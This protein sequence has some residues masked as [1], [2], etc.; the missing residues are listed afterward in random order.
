MRNAS[1]CW[2]ALFSSFLVCLSSCLLAWFLSKLHRL[3][4]FGGT[5]GANSATTTTKTAASPKKDEGDYKGRAKA[6][7]NNVPT[8]IISCIVAEFRNITQ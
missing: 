8:V 7:S 5:G 3:P 2:I 1:S 6:A 4:C